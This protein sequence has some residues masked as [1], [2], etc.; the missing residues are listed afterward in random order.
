MLNRWQQ[1]CSRL[2]APGN[3]GALFTILESLYAHPPRAYHNLD[4]VRACLDVLEEA[5]PLAQSADAVEL[6]L[7]LHDCVYDATRGDNEA[8]SAEVAGIFCRELHTNADLAARVHTLIMATRHQSV[9]LSGD[10][11]LIADIDLAG[12]AAPWEE[13]DANTWAIRKEYSF[14]SDADFR[15]GRA[16][17]FRGMLRKPVIYFSPLR[18]KYEAAARINMARSI[19]A[20]EYP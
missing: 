18:D 10:E 1:L 3:G 19:E 13:F 6:A 16:N 4:H 12:L 8:R 17:F 2:V 14:A 7:W 11:A 5:R 20:L 15:R 9:D